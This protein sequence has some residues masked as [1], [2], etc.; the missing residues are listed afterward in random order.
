[1]PKSN[2]AQ[3]RIATMARVPGASQARTGSMRGVNEGV[4]HES[5]ATKHYTARVRAIHAHDRGRSYGAPRLG[6]GVSM[7][8]GARP[9]P[10]RAGAET[11]PAGR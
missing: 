5:A 8:G 11:G 3:F 10:A 1:M 6:A 4:R 2:Q 9:G 7:Q